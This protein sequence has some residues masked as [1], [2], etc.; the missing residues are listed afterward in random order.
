MGVATPGM[1]PQVPLEFTTMFGHADVVR[2]LMQQVGIEGCGGESGGVEALRMAAVNCS[3]TNVCGWMWWPSCH[4]GGR[5]CGRH[6]RRRPVHGR[7]MW[8]RHSR[9][10][11]AATTA[12]GER[13]GEDSDGGASG[14]A[15][16]RVS[17]PLLPAIDFFV[18]S[19]G[20]R[21][22]LRIARLLVGAGADTTSAVQVTDQQGKMVSKDTRFVFMNR[23]RCLR[24]KKAGRREAD[25]EDLLRLEAVRRLLM[26]VEAMFVRFAGSGRPICLP[27]PTA[28][29]SST[30]VQTMRDE[31][32]RL[33]Q[34]ER[35]DRWPCRS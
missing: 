25:E 11:P 4:P 17:A 5:R 15:P 28:L 26:S 16:L 9:E 31:P 22:N 8:Q 24:E 35:R 2:E 12:A 34:L 29:P 33:R 1:G 6:G 30:V 23:S 10:V 13:H 32:R 27:S 7:G 3:A 14:N 21:A 19:T 18:V 20:R